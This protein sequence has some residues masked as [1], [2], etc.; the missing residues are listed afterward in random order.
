MDFLLLLYYSR[1]R[2]HGRA[3]RSCASPANLRGEQETAEQRL[4]EQQGTNQREGISVHSI[5][6]S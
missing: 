5:A 6:R 3:E 4:T 2:A 1:S